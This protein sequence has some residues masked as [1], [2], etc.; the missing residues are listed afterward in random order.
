MQNNILLLW[1]T[2]VDNEVINAAIEVV[3]V[4]N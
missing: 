4:G 1:H 3:M 2:F